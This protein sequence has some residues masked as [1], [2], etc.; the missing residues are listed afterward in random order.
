M[1]EVIQFLGRG[2]GA[3]I[4]NDKIRVTSAGP[5]IKNDFTKIADKIL[6]NDKKIDFSTGNF[7]PHNY[8]NY[9]DF[10]YKIVMENFDVKNPFDVTI[11]ETVK[12]FNKRPLWAQTFTEKRF[13]K[14]VKRPDS[15]VSH[16]IDDWDIDHWWVERELLL[17]QNQKEVLVERVNS[18]GSALTDLSVITSTEAAGLFHLR[19]ERRLSK[20][21]FS[22]SI[23]RVV[24]VDGGLAQ[25][26][27]TNIQLSNYFY[28]RG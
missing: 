15:F 20:R 25:F 10:Y 3:K 9:L 14:S 5:Y 22:A 1:S 17:D 21:S 16:G 13:L 26:L 7:I 4:F 27:D 2:E 23:G 19:T 8:Q 11:N 6:L 18:P 12:T 28:L 24:H